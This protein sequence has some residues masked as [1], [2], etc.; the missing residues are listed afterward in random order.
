MSKHDTGGC[1]YCAWWRR[2]GYA[3]C[4]AC[5]NKLKA[6]PSPADDF[7]G[8]SISAKRLVAWMESEMA[9]EATNNE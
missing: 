9:K 5:G 1:I 7:T 4:A 6:A 2:Q 8:F 3:F